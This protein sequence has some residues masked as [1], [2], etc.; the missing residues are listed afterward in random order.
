MEFAINIAILI[1]LTID[2]LMKIDHKYKISKKFNKRKPKK[3]N[4]KFRPIV[5]FENRDDTRRDAMRS[6]AFDNYF[7]RFQ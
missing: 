2:L 6:Q 7:R 5:N 4:R 3:Q 1:V